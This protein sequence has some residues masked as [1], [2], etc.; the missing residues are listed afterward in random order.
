MA[1]L[2]A[3]VTFAIMVMAAMALGTGALLGSTDDGGAA[4]KAAL[5]AANQ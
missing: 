5:Y 3:L 1:R 2:L 4:Q